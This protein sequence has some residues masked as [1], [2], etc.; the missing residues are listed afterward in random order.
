MGSLVSLATPLGWVG[1]KSV[2]G[3]GKVRERESGRCLCKGE[4]E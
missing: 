3:E 1:K 2:R 4:G